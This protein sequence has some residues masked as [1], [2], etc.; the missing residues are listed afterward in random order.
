MHRVS[1]CVTA[2]IQSIKII[3][4]LI[5]FLHYIDF[6]SILNMIV[7]LIPPDNIPS[8]VEYMKRSSTTLFSPP[9]G[10][11]VGLTELQVQEIEPTLSGVE[12]CFMLH[13]SL[14]PH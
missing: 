11:F 8:R 6:C 7:V 14:E 13:V 4:P 12:P 9:V 10:I 2:S 5:L 1:L 3:H